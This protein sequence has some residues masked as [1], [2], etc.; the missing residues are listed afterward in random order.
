MKLPDRGQARTLDVFD[1]A[2]MYADVYDV[3]NIEMQH[4]HILSTE[5]SYL[6]ELRSR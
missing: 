2:E 4:S 6:S 5:D 1:I 3:H